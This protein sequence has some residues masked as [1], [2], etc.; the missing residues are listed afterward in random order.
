MR[1]MHVSACIAAIQVR[2][3]SGGTLATLK[4]RAARA[5]RSLQ[6]YVRQLPGTGAATLMPEDAA[7]RA[8][9]ITARSSG[10]ADDVMDATAVI[11]QARQ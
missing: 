1:A 8:R 4:V 3:V 7:A 9:A 10:S 6:G 2:D 11:R 5:G